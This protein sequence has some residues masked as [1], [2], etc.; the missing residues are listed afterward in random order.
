MIEIFRHLHEF[1]KENSEPNFT[2]GIH[3]EIE[4]KDTSINR[5]PN[6]LN[7]RAR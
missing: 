6:K 1:G 5:A 4:G 2:Y 7:L 3:Y